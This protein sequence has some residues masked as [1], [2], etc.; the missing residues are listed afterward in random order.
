MSSVKASHS[1][2]GIRVAY[3]G[4]SS[5]R[6]WTVRHTVSLPQRNCWLRSGGLEG[7]IAWS[8]NLGCDVDEPIITAISRY[9]IWQCYAD[10]Q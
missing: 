5:S 7:S 8:L 2:M 10:K 6:I 3:D 1:L 4:E 9:V